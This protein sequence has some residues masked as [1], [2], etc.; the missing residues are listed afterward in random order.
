MSKVRGCE[1]FFEYMEVKEYERKYKESGYVAAGPSSGTRLSPSMERL[2]NN[3]VSYT[4]AKVHP[5]HVCS[6]HASQKINSGDAIVI[7][8]GVLQQSSSSNRGLKV[9]MTTNASFVMPIHLNLS[10][11]NFGNEANFIRI[12]TPDTGNCRIEY[13]NIHDIEYIVYV[14]TKT[15]KKDAQLLTPL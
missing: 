1:V 12:G 4:Y 14:A 15:I 5:V 7:C 13:K 2:L 10:T 9:S 11:T 8:T 3:G 6:L